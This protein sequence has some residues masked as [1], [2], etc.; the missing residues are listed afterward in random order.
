L[1]LK[2]ASRDAEEVPGANSYILLGFHQLQQFAFQENLMFPS[3]ILV[4][5]IR[6]QEGRL[7]AQVLDAS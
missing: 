3:L 2:T 7:M 1:V 5:D 6:P 4:G